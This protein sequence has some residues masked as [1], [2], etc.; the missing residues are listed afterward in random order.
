[1]KLSN[2]LDTKVMKL[3][4]KAGSSILNV[5]LDLLITHLRGH[6]ARSLAVNLE[7]VCK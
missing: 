4:W 1:M 7:L 5:C 3:L 2:Q 6:K